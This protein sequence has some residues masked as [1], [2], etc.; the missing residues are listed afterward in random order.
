VLPI[1]A[2]HVETWAGPELL[3]VDRKEQR[4]NG[5]TVHQAFVRARGR[6]GLTLSSHDVRHTGSTMAAAAGASPAGLKRRP[7]HSTTA[8]A[9]R[10]MHAIEGR[11]QRS[12][13]PCLTWPSSGTGLRSPARLALY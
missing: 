11:D 10:Y 2:E 8:A 6:L 7:G 9:L 4:I 5:A 3:R 1:L 13:P 12:R